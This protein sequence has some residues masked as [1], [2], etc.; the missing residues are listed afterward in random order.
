MRAAQFAKEPAT[1]D[2]Q[3]AK[4]E[5]RGCIIEDKTYAKFILEKINYYRLANYFAVYQ[6]NNKRYR[7]GTSFNKVLKLYEFDRKLRGHL[8]IF[9]EEIEISMR[10]AISNFHALKYGA[11]GY[12]SDS[13][14]NHH[15]NHH[16]FMSRID[17]L[18]EKNTDINFVSHYNSKHMGAFPLWVIMELFSFGMLAHFFK[19]L[20]RQDK[21]E[22]AERHFSGL[23]PA[24]HIESWLESMA[25]LRNHCAHYAR[26]YSSRLEPVP[27]PL[28]DL[29]FK[30]GGDLFSF[31]YVIKLMNKHLSGSE[32]IEAH[33]AALLEE[34]AEVA[35]LAVLG[36]PE[37]W[38]EFLE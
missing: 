6:Q 11:L 33:L 31:I 12:L 34:Y 15:H 8:L 25:A 26:L 10:A 18:K 13:A 3:L 16:H 17:R 2:A 37:N 30:M 36:F 29:S 9:L 5:F 27:K 22:I 1:I 19:S 32:K 24:G 28:D 7:G 38:E 14:F 20:H 23:F 21:K 35:E 4:L